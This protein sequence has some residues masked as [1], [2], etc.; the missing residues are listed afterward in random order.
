MQLFHTVVMPERTRAFETGTAGQLQ[1]QG[2]YPVGQW[3]GKTCRCRTVYYHQWL[4][5]SCGNMHQTRVIADYGAGCRHEVDCIAKARHAAQVLTVSRLPV[6]ESGPNP[7]AN[8]PVLCR[9]Q[10]PYLM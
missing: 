5:Q 8:F 7:V 10:N 3:R 4:A 6:I 2:P 9:T 1:R